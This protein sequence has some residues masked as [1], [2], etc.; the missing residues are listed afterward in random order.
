MC[1]CFVLFS[2]YFSIFFLQVALGLGIC[3]PPFPASSQFFGY[4]FVLRRFFRVAPLDFTCTMLC[5]SWYV[6]V[7]HCFSLISS[8][9]CDSSFSSL[10]F[11]WI[12]KCCEFSGFAAV[13]FQFYSVMID[14]N[15]LNWMVLYFVVNHLLSAVFVY[16]TVS[17]VLSPI[18]CHVVFL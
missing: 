14:F 5:G 7:I 18:M 10:T 16:S 13:C 8:F 2:F 1:V 12:F 9:S 17:Q 6:F 11:C 4:K 3:P 15:L